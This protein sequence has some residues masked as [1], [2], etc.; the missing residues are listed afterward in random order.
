M[1]IFL[2]WE[3]KLK[4]KNGRFGVEKK[5][6]RFWSMIPRQIDHSGAIA[7]GPGDQNIDVWSKTD[8]NQ[9]KKKSEKF[10]KIFHIFFLKNWSDKSML[11]RSSYLPEVKP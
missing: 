6:L 7:L 2:C 8:Q 10:G 11:L 9:V 5:I 4:M 1:T 3:A